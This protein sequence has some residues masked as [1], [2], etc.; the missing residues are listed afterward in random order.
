[1]YVSGA[2][3]ARVPSLQIRGKLR[4]FF[5]P[6]AADLVFAF[7]FIFPP[8]NVTTYKHKHVP[9]KMNCEIKANRNVCGVMT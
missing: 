1:M 5:N 3:R 2:D 8:L 9:E 4:P 7:A 6:D